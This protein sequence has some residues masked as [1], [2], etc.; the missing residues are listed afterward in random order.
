MNKKVII[1]IIAVILLV[2]VLGTILVACS[3]DSYKKKL[4]KKG[5]TVSAYTVDDD[6][7]DDIEWGV[8]ATKGLLGDAVYIVKFKSYDDAK[9]YEEDMRKLRYGSVYRTGK[10]VMYGSEQGV[11]DAK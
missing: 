9:D 3:A 10:I 8:M 6:D 7:Q 1:S 11:K 4:E 2:A 5:Y